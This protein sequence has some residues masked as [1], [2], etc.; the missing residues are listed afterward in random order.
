MLV[1]STI[2]FLTRATNF[3]IHVLSEKNHTQE[4]TERNQIHAPYE[5][6]VMT[7]AQR[8]T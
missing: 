2:P 7:T 8:L 3:V 6:E 5:R 1:S 4:K